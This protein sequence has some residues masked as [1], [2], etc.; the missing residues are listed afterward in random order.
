[1]YCTDSWGIKATVAL[2]QAL[3]LKPKAKLRGSGGHGLRGL[4]EIPALDWT[5][6]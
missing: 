2:M 6:H 3:C 5:V 1:M 4:L